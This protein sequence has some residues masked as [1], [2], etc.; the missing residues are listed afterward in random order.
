MPVLD[1]TPITEERPGRS[2]CPPALSSVATDE[3]NRLRA[4]GFRHI[5]GKT[6]GEIRKDCFLALMGAFYR[7]RMRSADPTSPHEGRGAPPASAP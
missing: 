1:K 3:L 7:D 6:E 4:E 2:S 5:T